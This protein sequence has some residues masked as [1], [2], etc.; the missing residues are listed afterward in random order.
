MIRDS[1]CVCLSVMTYVCLSV[2]GA[3]PIIRCPKGHAAEMIAERLDKK[4]RDNLRDARNC[5]FSGDNMPMAQ[6]R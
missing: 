2:S 3:I 4:I 1:I 6:L 5:L